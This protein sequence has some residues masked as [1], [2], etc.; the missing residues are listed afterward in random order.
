MSGLQAHVDEYLRL[1]RALGFKLREDERLLGQ[2]VGYLD[3]AGASTVTSELAIGWARLPV[4]VH[5]NRWAK[6]LRIARGFAAYLQTIDPTAEIP[7]P[8][9][10]PVRRQ[11]AT[12]YLFSQRDIC[13]LLAEA[14]RLRHPMRAASYEALFGLLAVSGMRI[15]EAI[16][17]GRE[18]VDLDAGLITIRKAKG[19]RARLVPLHP[20]AAEALHR[21][22]SARDRLCPT[23]RSRAFFLSSAG[24]PVLAVS[25][26]ATFREITT[27]IGIRTQQVRPRIHD[28]RHRFAVQT[29]IDWYRSGENI[30][31]HIAT[32]STYLGHI[33]PADTYWYFSASPELMAL[34]AER[35]ADRFGG[36]R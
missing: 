25:L 5:P 12:P 17:L 29:L 14:R 7:P 19:D 26:G 30:D 31:E 24:T 15:G 21:Y 28:L 9:V 32:L 36:V 35:V 11:R 16:A 4:G 22:A 3:A 23:P 8:D 27:R 13:L 33:S 6:R 34:A 1:R 20:T 18:D 10:F 2:F